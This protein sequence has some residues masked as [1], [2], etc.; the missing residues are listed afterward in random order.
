MA[1]S[2]M[3]AHNNTVKMYNL[4]TL[5][6]VDILTGVCIVQN[7]QNIHPSATSYNRHSHMAYKYQIHSRDNGL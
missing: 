6:P 7:G 1:I 3:I 5:L 2:P 4:S